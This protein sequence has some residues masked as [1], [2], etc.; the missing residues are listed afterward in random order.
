MALKIGSIVIKDKEY[1]KI[2][3]TQ[4]T[5]NIFAKE[6]A[7]YKKL[8]ETIN[9]PYGLGFSC[10]IEMI[11]NDQELMDKFIALVRSK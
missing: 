5:T 6:L 7:D 3:T 9:R 4:I 2:Q 10:L 11:M 8:M 1:Q